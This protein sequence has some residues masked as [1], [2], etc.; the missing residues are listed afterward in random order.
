MTATP[1]AERRRT[2]IVATVGPASREPETLR[3]L[4]ANQ[5]PI[6][7]IERGAQKVTD[8]TELAVQSLLAHGR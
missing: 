4:I 6:Q 2:K 8:A 5:A 3:Q 7:A 1:E